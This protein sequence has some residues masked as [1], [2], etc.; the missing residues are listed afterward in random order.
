MAAFDRAKAADHKK[1]GAFFTPASV[2]QFLANWAIRAETD[3]VLEPSCGEASFL[4]AACGSRLSCVTA[5]SPARNS[6][7]SAVISHPSSSRRT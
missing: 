3:K 6:R 4:V 5:S 2:S 7:P 1:R